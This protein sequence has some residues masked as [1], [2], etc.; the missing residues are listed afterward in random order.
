MMRL[1]ST[2][3]V[4]ALMCANTAWADPVTL[5]DTQLGQIVAGKEFIIT[6][7]VSDQAGVAPVTDAARTR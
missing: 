6:N 1:L 2:A 5:A 3:A 7:R 4:V